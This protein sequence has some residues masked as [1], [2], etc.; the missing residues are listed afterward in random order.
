MNTFYLACREGSKQFSN[1]GYKQD[2]TGYIASSS[3]SEKEQPPANKGS[4]KWLNFQCSFY[5][6]L[7]LEGCMLAMEF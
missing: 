7:H 2:D 3:F 4:S 6:A 1:R 5:F